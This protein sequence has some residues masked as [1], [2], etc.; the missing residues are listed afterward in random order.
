MWRY[1]LI[2]LS[3]TV[4][5]ACDGGNPTSPQIHGG[6]KSQVP[7]GLLTI[8]SWLPFGVTATDL[9]LMTRDLEQELLLNQIQFSLREQFAVED[10]RDIIPA[11]LAESIV[12][13]DGSLTTEQLTSAFI[14][15]TNLT[16]PLYYEPR[17]FSDHDK[18]ENWATCN[19]RDAF[20]AQCD[21]LPGFADTVQTII[22]TLQEQ[23]AALNGS[24]SG[25]QGYLV[26]NEIANEN[27][28]PEYYAAMTKAIEV[29][30]AADPDRP[31]LVV[32]VD[33]EFDAAG[34]VE[35]VM[36]AFFRGYDPPNIFQ[37]DHYVFRKD[38]PREA[39]DP[40]QRKKKTVQKQLD[41]LLQGYDR[42]CRLVVENKGRWH[43]I[44]QVQGEDR[45]GQR[46]SAQ[47]RIPEPGEIGVQVGLGLSRGASG[48]VYFVHGSGIEVASG[49]QY[50]GLVDVD[51][52]P[53]PRYDTVKGINGYLNSIRIELESLYFH[54][55]I[56]WIEADKSSEIPQN[57][58]FRGVDIKRSDGGLDEGGRLEFGVFGDGEDNTHL[59]VVNRRT[60]SAQTVE[61]LVVAEPVFDVATGEELEVEDTIVRKLRLDRKL[62]IDLEPGGFRLLRFE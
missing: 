25:L 14:Q 44:V 15:Q 60:H 18:L 59:L 45:P 57:G 37:Q 11:F 61:L 29:I 4:L 16:M 3:T 35:E 31:A 38:I 34:S 13:A 6:E 56:S 20:K 36:R 9:R 24:L 49:W 23:Y 22:R 17:G 53:T 30:R 27:Y 8:G 39:E 46:L 55:S 19:F 28:T 62:S 33:T 54:A 58:L 32:S 42:V 47:L 2:M 43:A 21:T 5:A 52:N 7:I 48:I 41:K 26:M 1:A 12:A 51:G 40:Q 50:H 10:I